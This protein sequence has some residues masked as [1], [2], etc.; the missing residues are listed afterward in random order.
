MATLVAPIQIIIFAV[1]L[2]LCYSFYSPAWFSYHPVFM[3]LGY[4]GFMSNAIFF[5]RWGANHWTHMNLQLIS[6]ACIDFAY[7]VIYT[8]K[9]MAKKNHNTTWHS[10]IGLGCII[11]NNIQALGSMYSLWPGK[12]KKQI[13]PFDIT[14][15]KWGGRIMF[16]SI[17][18]T[19]HLGFYKM[20]STKM[21]QV[22]LFDAFLAAVAVTC[23]T[24]FIYY[25]PLW[26][27][28]RI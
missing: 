22:Y 12:S 18:I 2:F 14:M 13:K 5:E 23:L 26:S 25:K 4:L 9:N 27:K 24:K 19:M 8:N 17:L 21:M 7:Y 11:L 15:H 6:L 10:W 20:R 1:T 28:I 3:M 16:I